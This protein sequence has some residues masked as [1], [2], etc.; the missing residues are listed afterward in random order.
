MFTCPHT[1]FLCSSWLTNMPTADRERLDDFDRPINQLLRE[2]IAGDT[3]WHIDC[4]S[5]TGKKSLRTICSRRAGFLSSARGAGRVGE[6]PRILP[7][8]GAK[9]LGP[10]SAALIT[11]IFS[12][13]TD[14]S[15]ESDASLS[16]LACLA[17]GKQK[18]RSL[19]LPH[20]PVSQKNS[21][22]QYT[23]DVP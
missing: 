2:G 1:S 12:H 17:T 8:S 9:R 14:L 16:L 19:L 10:G 11:S 5:P 18:G 15:V 23:S 4:D 3:S 21:C 13:F 22:L 6:G 20:Q 7:N